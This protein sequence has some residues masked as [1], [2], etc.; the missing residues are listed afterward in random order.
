MSFTSFSFFLLAG[1][2]VCGYYLFPEKV[3]WIWLLIVSGLY[4]A[5]A[6]TAFLPY[7]LFAAAVTWIGGLF[8]ANEKKAAVVIPLLLDFGM[9]A[10]LK[11]STFAI[12]TLNRLPGISLPGVYLLLPLGISFYTFQTAGYLLDVYWKRIEPEK[13]FFHYLLFT[14][15]FPQL[16]QGP[17]GRYGTLSPQLIQGHAFEADHIWRGLWR[18]SWGMFKKYVVAD[19]AALYVDRIF[20]A[21][22]DLQS[23]GIQGVLLYSVQLYADFSAGIDVALGIAEMMGIHLDE[24]FR[25][26]YFARSLTD[27]WHRW[28]ITLGTWMKDYLFY[29]ITLSGWMGKLRKSCRKAFGKETGRALPIG[30][31]NLIVFAAVGIWHGPS[32]HFIA[33]GLFHGMIIA[34]SGLLTGTF[35]KWKQKLGVTDQ[36][37]WFT[38]FCIARTFLLVNI[39]WY[40]D[41]SESL[42][43]VWQMLKNSFKAPFFS[44]TVIEPGRPLLCLYHFIPMLLG[45]LVILAVSILR[46]KGLD[47]RGKATSWPA[48]VQTACLIAIWL[49][50][51]FY[52]NMSDGGFIYANF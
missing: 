20:G 16:M 45:C 9:L 15:F 52:G 47:V 21:S 48:A 12:L 51:A 41:R 32:W 6:G 42:R 2:C 23:L 7:L 26:P 24:N 29:P 3:R 36:T 14:A 1:G 5:A 25:Q 33:F 19:N 35:R 28:H 38:A 39:S 31:A 50:C 49:I 4:Y 30:I 44:L 10:W 46:E 17:I 40:L 13:N 34:I 37:P 11:Y 22:F 18:I 43:M 8:A 27:F